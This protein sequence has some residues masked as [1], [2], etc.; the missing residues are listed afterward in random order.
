MYGCARTHEN[1]GYQVAPE[2]IFFGSKVVIKKVNHSILGMIYFIHFDLH[3]IKWLFIKNHA[4][5]IPF[6][7]ASN[8]YKMNTFLSIE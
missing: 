2:W 6:N 8:G 4:L 5:L 1:N 7:H 3:V